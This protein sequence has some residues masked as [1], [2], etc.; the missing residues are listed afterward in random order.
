MPALANYASEGVLTINSVALNTPAWHVGGDETGEGSLLQLWGLMTERRGQN[1]LVPANAGTI[2]YRH[3]GTETDY[4]LRATIIGDVN[5]AGVPYAD[6]RVGLQTNL[7]TWVTLIDTS[8][9]GDGTVTASLTRF[10]GGAITAP[11]QVMSLTP[12]L[13]SYSPDG[14]SGSVLIG[15]LLLKIPSGRLS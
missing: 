15:D 2:A 7:D 1:R 4:T 8:G 9:S 10:T 12:T 14:K 11:V 3:R 6:D 13:I 5:S